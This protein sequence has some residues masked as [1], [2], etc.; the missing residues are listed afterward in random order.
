MNNLIPMAY[1]Y[2]YGGGWTDWLS[3]LVISALVH[4]LIY[5]FIFHLMHELTLGQAAVLIAVVL[6]VLFIWA[7]ARD[8]RGW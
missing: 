7:R 2:S 1:H 6:V 8:R 3:H 5:G 4:A